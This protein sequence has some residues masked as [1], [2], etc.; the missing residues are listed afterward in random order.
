[1]VASG[2]DC[3]TRSSGTRRATSAFAIYV[4]V[5]QMKLTARQQQWFIYGGFFLAA[6]LFY[7]LIWSPLRDDMQQLRET[8]KQ[9]KSAIVWME[10]AVARIIALR[11]TDKAVVGSEKNTLGLIEQAI[12]NNPVGASSA[13]L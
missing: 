3:Q 8:V 10:P 11:K 1:M 4:R 7:S 9:K 13:I 6:I 2:L 12:Q 5:D